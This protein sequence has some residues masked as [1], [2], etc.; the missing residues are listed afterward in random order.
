MGPIYSKLKG[1]DKW[2]DLLDLQVAK[3]QTHISYQ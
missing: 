3:K 1:V 2:Y